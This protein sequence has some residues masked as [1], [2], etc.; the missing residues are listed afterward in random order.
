MINFF[1]TC[2]SYIT[3]NTG[4]SLTS[5]TISHPAHHRPITQY[6]YKQEIMETYWCTITNDIRELGKGDKIP[7]ALTPC[8]RSHCVEWKNGECIHS[9]KPGNLIV[10]R[11]SADKLRIPGRHDVQYLF[12]RLGGTNTSEGLFSDCKAKNYLLYITI[13]F[14]ILNIIERFFIK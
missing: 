11:S 10:S 1:M 2:K 5:G 14:F 6:F 9:A 7:I 3:G 4:L 13:S 12:A 8:L